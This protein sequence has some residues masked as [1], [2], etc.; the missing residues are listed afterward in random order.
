MARGWRKKA[1]LH[2]QPT[3]P[4]EE[5]DR[6]SSKMKRRKPKSLHKIKRFFGTFPFDINI[7]EQLQL[8]IT[9]G[10]LQ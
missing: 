7:Q 4:T 2:S 5:D 3:M 1:V 10:V 8:V 6:V 9:K